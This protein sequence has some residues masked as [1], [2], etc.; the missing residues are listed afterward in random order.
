MDELIETI[1]DNAEHKGDV[2]ALVT[3]LLMASEGGKELNLAIAN[4]GTSPPWRW[5]DGVYEQC[6]TRDQYG[7]GAVGNPVCSLEYF[8]ERLD[9][10]MQLIPGNWRVHSIAQFYGKW[11]VC[12]HQAFGA[13]ED[14]KIW[15]QG[16]HWPGKYNSTAEHKNLAIAICAAAIQARG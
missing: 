3:R 9:D 2:D 11:S 15:K 8:T 4:L 6:V 14:Q 12:L 13:E 5:H 1:R 10:A 16:H 7:P